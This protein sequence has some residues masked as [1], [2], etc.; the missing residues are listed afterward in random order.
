[1]LGAVTAASPRHSALDLDRKQIFRR[2]VAVQA[3]RGGIA[4]R[5]AAWQTPRGASNSD[6]GGIA[7]PAEAES[8]VLG[9][10]GTGG[11]AGTT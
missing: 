6:L 11:E 3:S 1:M 7:G 2:V 9:L 10:G 5:L 4:A 8:P